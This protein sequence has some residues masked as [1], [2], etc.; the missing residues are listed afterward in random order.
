MGHEELFSY[1]NSFQIVETDQ[2]REQER[3]RFWERRTHLESAF[4]KPQQVRNLRDIESA[5][6][7]K[8][9]IVK[10]NALVLYRCGAERPNG[11]VRGCLLGGV[12][13]IEGDLYWLSHKV[14]EILPFSSDTDEAPQSLA[15]ASEAGLIDVNSG[16]GFRVVEANRL[17]FSDHYNATGVNCEHTDEHLSAEKILNDIENLK[18]ENN[19]TV[20]LTNN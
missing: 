6:N 13:K 12:F 10:S 7:N 8:P 16:F 2:Q 17:A 5:I 1:L 15:E 9:S 18:R 14:R 19:K 20:Y 4:S 3:R 11:A